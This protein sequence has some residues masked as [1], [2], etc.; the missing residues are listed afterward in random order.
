VGEVRVIAKNRIR[1]AVRAEG[2]AAAELEIRLHP[3]RFGGWQAIAVVR[4]GGG[5]PVPLGR[6]F[7]AQDRRPAAAKMVAWVRRHYL[8]TQPLAERRTARPAAVGR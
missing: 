7:R 4:P 3:D 2:G 5:A 6:V 8:E 1:F